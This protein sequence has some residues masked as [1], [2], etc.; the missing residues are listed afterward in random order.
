MRELEKLLYIFTAVYCP[1]PP[2]V[3]EVGALNSVLSSAP[4]NSGLYS[5]GASVV[6][7]CSGG[8]R[9]EDGQMTKTIV[10]NQQGQWN[11]TSFNCSG[12]CSNPKYSFFLTLLISILLLFLTITFFYFKI[13]LL[14]FKIYCY[15]NKYFVKHFSLHSTLIL[16]SQL[17]ISYN[18]LVA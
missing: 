11:E 10:C 4:S 15:V 14:D 12:I 1:V 7:F 3:T 9:F 17:L 8:R 16:N 13:F 2:T 5:Y 6:Y 18:K